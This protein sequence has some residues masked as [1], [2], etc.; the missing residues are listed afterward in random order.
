MKRE[1]LPKPVPKKKEAA[2]SGGFE[3]TNGM[4]DV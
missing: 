4:K 3:R 2:F 1:E